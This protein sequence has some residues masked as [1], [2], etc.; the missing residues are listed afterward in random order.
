[1]TSTGYVRRDVVAPHAGSVDRNNSAD[2]ANREKQTSLPTR[3]A[4]I[5]IASAKDILTALNQVAPHA[6]SVDRNFQYYDAPFLAAGR[7]PRGERG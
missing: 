2:Y 6:G 7:S 4:W 3:G 1:M 5:E